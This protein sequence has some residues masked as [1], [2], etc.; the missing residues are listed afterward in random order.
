MFARGYS[1][2]VIEFDPKLDLLS[3]D[4]WVLPAPHTWLQQPR[5]QKTWFDKYLVFEIC[6]NNDSD[7][8]Y[9]ELMYPP[10]N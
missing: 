1:K 2:I 9:V 5:A 7:G 8:T 4:G 10:V 3:L 6:T